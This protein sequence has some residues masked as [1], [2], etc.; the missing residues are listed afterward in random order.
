MGCSDEDVAGDGGRV[1]NH[2]ELILTCYL[3]NERQ[4]I[5]LAPHI[6]PSYCDLEREIIKALVKVLEAKNGFDKV[7]YLGGQRRDTL[8]GK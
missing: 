2:T 7:E 1:L 4:A 6:P 8:R 5:A 3:G